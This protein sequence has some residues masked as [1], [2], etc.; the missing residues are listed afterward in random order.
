M[1]ELAIFIRYK[2]GIEKICIYADAEVIFNVY[3]HLSCII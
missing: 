2:T 3:M 1:T